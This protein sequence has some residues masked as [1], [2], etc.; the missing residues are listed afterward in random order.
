MTAPLDKNGLQSERMPLIDHKMLISILALLISLA[1]AA[2]TVWN[3]FYKDTTIK[4]Q[5]LTS[6]LDKLID[7]DRQA[8]E[9]NTLPI[10]PDQKEFAHFSLSNRAYILLR[11]ADELYKS[12]EKNRTLEDTLLLSIVHFRTGNY[13]IAKEY[14]LKVLKELEVSEEALNNKKLNMYATT[15]RSLAILAKSEGNNSEATKYF[16]QALDLFSSPANDTERIFRIQTKHIMTQYNIMDF[17]YDTAAKDL[18]QLSNELFEMACT[19]LRGE[20]LFRIYNTIQQI[21]RQLDPNIDMPTQV[22]DKPKCL[23]DPFYENIPAQ[24]SRTD[25]R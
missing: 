2:F 9:L 16:K 1:V 5:E 11:Q 6:I 13:Q 20:W 21:N 15:L 24:V 7:L 10:T 4:R 23:Y 8:T 12:T 19:P 25:V 22:V 3:E 18:L 14:L 17:D